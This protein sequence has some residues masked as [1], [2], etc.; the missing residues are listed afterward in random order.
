MVDIQIC[1]STNAS[2]IERQKYNINQESVY[3]FTATGFAENAY[4]GIVTFFCP[5]RAVDP[6]LIEIIVNL[7]ELAETVIAWGT[8]FGAIISFCR[9]NKNYEYLITIKRKKKDKEIEIEIPIDGNEDSKEDSKEIINKV[10]KW[11]ND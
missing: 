2:E 11:F 5:P 1:V 7:K 8:I 6:G 10:K 4:E 9:K 3:E